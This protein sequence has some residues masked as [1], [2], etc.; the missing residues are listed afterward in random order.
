ME[1]TTT[2]KENSAMDYDHYIEATVTGHTLQGDPF[3]GTIVGVSNGDTD[4][5]PIF[6]IA[7]DGLINRYRLP[8]FGWVGGWLKIKTITFA[9]EV[10]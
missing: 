10:K 1:A 7:I 6:R 2:T 3:A 8:E 9:T 4:S 5:G